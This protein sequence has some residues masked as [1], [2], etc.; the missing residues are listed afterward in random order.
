MSSIAF[1]EGKAVYAELNMLVD[2]L[3]SMDPGGLSAAEHRELMRDKEALARRLPALCHASI[4]WLAEHATAAEVGASLRNTMADDL[5]ITRGEAARRI[6]EAADLGPRQTLT[7]EP[8]PPK[9]ENTAAGQAAGAISTEAV[10]IIRGCLGRLPHW[11]DE[12][13]RAETERQL[14]MVAAGSRPD[15]LEQFAEDVEL[16]LNPDGNFSDADR[17]HRR[18]ITIGPQGPD[19]TSP[20]SGHLTP[21]LVAGLSAI[22]AKWAAPGTCN[23]ADRT[24]TLHG[25]PDDKTVAG[26]CRSTAQRN[27][28]ALNMIV[29]STLMSKNLGSHQGLPVTI[30]ATAS[31]EDLQNKTGVAR[32]ATG[33]KLPIKDVIRMSAHAYHFLLLFD[34]AKPCQLYKGRTTRLATPAQRLVLTATERGCTRPG[35]TVPA[36]WCQVHHVKDWAEGGPTDMDNLTLSCGP[37]N[38][39]A[40]L[41]GWSTRKRKDGTTEWIPPP[42]L[43]RGQP[44]TNTYWHPENMLGDREPEEPEEPG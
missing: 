4:T 24:P 40:D 26:D 17:A 8:L 5:R 38:R 20:I 23:P 39:L 2:K 25:Q 37:D 12:P 43:D 33:T 10:R 7:G 42:H 31:L 3:A 16:M 11:I 14:A 36:A 28:D 15:Q 27:H 32:T 41:D 19:G 18:G 35:C 34:K 21:E 1:D 29:R 30:V 9:F 22:Y 6:K 44:H 13:T